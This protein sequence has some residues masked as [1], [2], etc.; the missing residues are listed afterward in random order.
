MVLGAVEAVVELGVEGAIIADFICFVAGLD[1][2]GRGA[3]FEGFER[4]F[5]PIM[6]F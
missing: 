3:E 4:G 6:L 2:T 5:G 1:P